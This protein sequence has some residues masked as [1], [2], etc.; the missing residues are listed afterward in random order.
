ML[1]KCFSVRWDGSC[2]ALNVKGCPGKWRCSFFRTLWEHETDLEAANARLRTLT[3]ALQ[4]E[5]SERYY[6]GRMPWR[7]NKE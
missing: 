3:D 5:I 4:S 6:K 1:K 7:E 2:R